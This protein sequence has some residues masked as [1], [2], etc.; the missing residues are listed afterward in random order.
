MK[1]APSSKGGLDNM[2]FAAMTVANL[3][4]MDK[5]I[6]SSGTNKDLTQNFIDSYITQTHF[7]D[8]DTPGNI[9]FMGIER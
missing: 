5:K 2:A 8:D 3:L 7:G 9:F 1:I 6:K 4:L